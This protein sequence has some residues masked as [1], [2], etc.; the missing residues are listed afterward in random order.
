MSL[1]SKNKH[2]IAL[3]SYMFMCRFVQFLSQSHDTP[4]NISSSKCVI[5]VRKRVNFKLK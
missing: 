4:S 5:L 3:K 1:I 2:Q